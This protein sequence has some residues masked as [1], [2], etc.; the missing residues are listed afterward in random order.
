[1]I[2]RL[3]EFTSNRSYIFKK[4]YEL[5]LE[6]KNNFLDVL[7]KSKLYVDKNFEKFYLT[8]T[9]DSFFKEGCEKFSYSKN[10]TKMFFQIFLTKFILVNALRFEEKN[11]F[12]FLEA[13][14]GKRE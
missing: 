5:Y 1:M 10:G 8:D 6:D 3:C 7:T 4:A 14:L 12:C 9:A 2:P 13:A 11:I